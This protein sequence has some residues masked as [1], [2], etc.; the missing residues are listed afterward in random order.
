[1]YEFT[2]TYEYKWAE[3]LLVR[4]EYRGDFSNVSYF[5]KLA[6]QTRRPAVHADGSI[7]SPS[8]APSVEKKQAELA[9][10][11]GLAELALQPPSIG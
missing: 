1:L 9:E 2:A 4:A 8:S 11:A 5:H 7:S 6:N 10:L 3:G